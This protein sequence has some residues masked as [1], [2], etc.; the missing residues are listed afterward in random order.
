MIM[1]INHINPT[2]DQTFLQ[3]LQEESIRFQKLVGEVNK[4][5]I[6]HQETIQYALMAVLCKGHIL[7]EGVPGVAKTTMIKAITQA[8]GLTFK[9][10]QFTPDLLPSDLVGT[11]IYNQ[12]TLE[13]E[14]KKGP[15]FAHLI[16]ADEINRAPAKVQAALLEAMQ[17]RQ[18]TLGNSTFTLDDPFLVFAT[19][20]PIEQE[21]TYRLPEAQV[22]RFFF[23]LIVNY[24]TIAEEKQVL[25]R[26]QIPA[27]IYPVLT[28][29]DIVNAQACVHNIYMDEK[30]VDYILQIV[31]ATRSPEQYKLAELKEYIACGASPRATL[32]FHHAAKAHAFLKKRHFVIPDDVKAVAYA[33]LRHRITTT[34]QA[35]AEHVTVEKVIERILSSIKAP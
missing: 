6:G 8:L 4:V 2:V 21:G 25:Y 24:P 22:D 29:D 33:I 3:N 15:I 9:R 14:T 17:E 26:S 34:Y 5:I 10:I 18:V 28:K 7:L 1:E 12:K 20:N 19:Q 31:F 27:T 16:L 13:F 23:K 35:D 30:I 11:L 32:A